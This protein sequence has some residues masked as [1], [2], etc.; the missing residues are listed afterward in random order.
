MGGGFAVPWAY[1]L[2]DVASEEAVAEEGGEFG[3]LVAAEFDG[4]VGDAAAGV[5]D[6]WGDDGAGRAGVDAAGAGAAPVDNLRY[7]LPGIVGCNSGRTPSRIL[8]GFTGK[9]GLERRGPR[10][11]STGRM[12]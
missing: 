9:A 1:F 12:D 6:A 5:D 10:N 8:R 4:L 2:A 3:V 11:H 7:D